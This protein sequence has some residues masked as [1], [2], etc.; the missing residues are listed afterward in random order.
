MVQAG[1]VIYMKNTE[2]IAVCIGCQMA[3]QFGD[4]EWGTDEYQLEAWLEDLDYRNPG[5]KCEI[6]I[7]GDEVEEAAECGVC[8]DYKPQEASSARIIYTKK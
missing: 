7:I 1:I 3:L 4:Y 6:E 5:Y 2:E 8:F